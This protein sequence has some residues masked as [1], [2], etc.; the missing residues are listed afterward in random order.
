M[1]LP[2]LVSHPGTEQLES[3][4]TGF[5]PIRVMEVELTKPL[6]S[7]AWD[8]R[9]RQVWIVA[10]LHTEPIG[11]CLVQ[12][13]REGLTPSQ[14][15]TLL[16]AE[17]QAP[18]N[19]RFAA[20]RLPA[21][22]R[23]DSAGLEADPGAWPFLRD[24]RAVLAAG[25]LISVVI[26]TRDRPDQV[27]RCLERLNR[28]EYPRF[29]VV[30]VENVPTGDSVRQLVASQPGHIPYRYV[31]E[32]RPGVSWA[33]N[34]GIAATAGEIIAFLDDDEQPDSHWLAGLAQGFARSRKVGCVTGKILPAALDTPAQELFERL[35]GHSK[36]REFER[37]TFSRNGPQS[38]F[39]PLP[40]FGALANMGFRREALAKIGG[41]DVALG[42]GTPSQAGSD[43]LAL[44]MT[45]LSGYDIAYEPA[46]PDVALPPRGCRESPKP[47]LWL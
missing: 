16:W 35:G 22:T 2:R 7:I 10:R 19:Q 5:S 41:M 45:L 26:P 24:R 21:P 37:I 27:A 1:T 25:P 31:A 46:A 6:P 44:T 23:I 4:D 29:E 12:L 47:T 18:V 33:R 28:Q 11:E 38:P 36:G 20:A 42:A 40:A 13:G 32:P 30:V 34:T 43:T 8:G 14:L 3:S 15:G 39:F 17:L 9:Y